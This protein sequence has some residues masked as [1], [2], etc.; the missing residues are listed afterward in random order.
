MTSGSARYNGHSEWYDQTFSA[1]HPPREELAF[2]REALGIGNGQVCVDRACGTGLCAQPIADAGYRSAVFDISAD[3]LR[4]ARCRLGDGSGVSDSI[5]WR[6]FCPRDSGLLTRG[7][8]Q[9]GADG[10]AGCWFGQSG[11]WVGRLR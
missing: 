1:F 8:G 6:P 9:A 7:G 4:F 11:Y 5:S 3:Q 2:L 10:R